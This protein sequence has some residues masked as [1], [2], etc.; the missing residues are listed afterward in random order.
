V[1]TAGAVSTTGILNANTYTVSGTDADALGDTGSWTYTLTV[2]APT[3]GSPPPPTTTLVQT[4]PASGTTTTDNS[5]AFTAGP[6]TV[7]HATGAVTFL[8]TSP[9]PGLSVSAQG[10]VTTTGPLAVGSY[11][12]SGTESDPN[13]DTGTWVFSLTVNSSITVTF[14]ANGGQG[15]MASETKSLATALTPNVFTWSKHAFDDWNTAANGS[16]TSYANGAVYSFTAST[17]LYAQWTTTTH[18]AVTHR[19]TFDANGGA[20]SMPS[21]AKNVLASLTANRFTRKGFSF[22]DWNTASNGSGTS[23]DNYSAYNFKK[24][25]TLYAQWRRAAATFDVRFHANGG[26]GSMK[27]ETKKA[28]APLTL[29]KFIRSGFKFIKWSTTGNGSG[30]D[31]ANGQSYSF[32]ASISLYAQWS[33]VA[34]VVHPAVH[35][36]V[37]LS[38]FGVKSSALTTTLESQVSALASE[39]KINHDTKIALVGYSGDLTTANQSNEAAWAASL[40]L[41]QQ[42]AN[43]VKEDLT[44]QLALLGVTRFS[45]TAVGSGAAISPS[46]NA[47]ASDQARNRKVV[48]T[49]T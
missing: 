25:T 39:I 15:S 10:N 11:S 43:A 38:P 8:T 9:S 49:I 3:G 40:K 12:A 26:T 21:E 13:G 19:V 28:A 47:T 41:S 42:R 22:V 20:G 6:I 46:S 45:I 17:T 37:A 36:V 18:V 29:N 44:L 14:V 2:T 23:Y 32:K 24:S 30:S 5:G 48:A 16:G 31:Y 7:S 4:S 35:A 33:A 1:S 27:T 34:P